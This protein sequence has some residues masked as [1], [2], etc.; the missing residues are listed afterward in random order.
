MAKVYF[1]APISS[2]SG[3][4]GD[5]IY[6]QSKGVNLVR[7]NQPNPAYPNS[8][9]QQ[10]IKQNLIDLAKAW[11]T[12]TPVQ[13]SLWKGYAALLGSRFSG[14]TAFARLNAALLGASHADLGCIYSPPSTPSTP[15]HSV[16]FCVFLVN[17]TLNCISWSSPLLTTLYTT[18]KF[19]LHSSFCKQFPCY[20]D[21]LTIGYRPS[22]RFVETVRSD[23]GEIL[24]S[25]SWPAGTQMFFRINTIDPFG[26]KSPFTHQISVG[27]SQ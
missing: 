23:A 1:S 24:H 3:K 19:R 13:Q 27:L 22:W 9:D 25:H 21:C 15:K 11:S 17:D 5:Q 26:R 6:Y 4:L 10:R 2:M 12:L 16:G 20:G 7:T 8:P 18:A 14:N